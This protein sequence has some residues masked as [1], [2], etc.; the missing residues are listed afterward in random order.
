MMQTA[1]HKPFF[2]CHREREGKSM[3]YKIAGVVMVGLAASG[4]VTT[5]E[6]ATPDGKHNVTV[7]AVRGC[8]NPSQTITTV[9]TKGRKPI[10]FASTGQD[11]CN[12]AVGGILGAAGQIGGAMAMPGSNF[13]ISSGAVVNADQVV[14]INP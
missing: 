8:G 7:T 14:R 4:C 2:L 3:F 9:E 13:V 5:R 12:T 1:K 11:L 6:Y 10:H